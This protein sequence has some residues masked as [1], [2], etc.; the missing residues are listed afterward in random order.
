MTCECSGRVRESFAELGHDA[1]SCDIQPSE[2]PGQHIQANVLSVLDRGWDMMIAHPPCTY[3]SNAGQRWFKVQPDRMD[4]AHDAMKF[5]L[6]L[7]NAPIPRIA[8]ENPRGLSWS[9]FRHPDQ[10][11][12]P[13][14]FGEPYTKATCLWLKQLPPLLYTEIIVDPFVNWAK[15]NGKHD[16][17]TRS[18]TPWGIARAMANQWNVPLTKGV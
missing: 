15:Y 2:L 3:L 7:W 13:W 16:A 17:K 6:A 1:W 5:F 12:Q 10:I 11:I 9:L 18:R 8:I 4:K 14:Q